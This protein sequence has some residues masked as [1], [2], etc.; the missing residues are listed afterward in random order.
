MKTRQIIFALLILLIGTL[1][2]FRIKPS[3]GGYGGDFVAS[4]QR[5]VEAQGYTNVQYTG[6]DSFACGELAGFAFDADNA[7]H[8]RVR[9]VA[10][11]P[12]GLVNY[13]K[14]WWIVTR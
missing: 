10:C 3:G 1:V 5:A 8:A 14:G 13:A 2:Y 7:N 12:D 9:L 11:N 6:I 4:A